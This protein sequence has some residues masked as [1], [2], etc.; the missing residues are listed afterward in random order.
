MKQVVLTALPGAGRTPTMQEAGET[1]RRIASG[2]LVK[3][4]S[5]SMQTVVNVVAEMMSALEQNRVSKSPKVDNPFIVQV[6]AAMSLWYTGEALEINA[7][8]GEAAALAAFA[9]INAKAQA[10]ENVS[11]ATTQGLL[12][13][14]WLLPDSSRRALLKLSD[15]APGTVVTL[16]EG[17]GKA[18]T[19]KGSKQPS[20]KSQVAALFGSPAMTT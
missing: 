11:F 15:S 3:F 19:P 6:R 4:A 1:M 13:F 5:I 10:G 16:A 20:A 14:G 17:F 2:A 9:A 18:S 12:V 7:A 8:P